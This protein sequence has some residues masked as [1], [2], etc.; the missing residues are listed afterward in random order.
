MS[1]TRCGKSFVSRDPVVVTVRPIQESSSQEV[2]KKATTSAI[3]CVS[4]Q[5]DSLVLT[6]TYTLKTGLVVLI[7]KTAVV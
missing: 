2:S 7:V 4:E 3:F 1:V 5:T 6:F